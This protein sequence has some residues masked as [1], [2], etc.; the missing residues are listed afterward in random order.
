LGKVNNLRH[1][2]KIFFLDVKISFCLG[3]GGVFYSFGFL[4]GGLC[5]GKNQM[6]K[7]CGGIFSE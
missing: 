6:C 2:C 1:L 4:G 7:I 3:G 5:D